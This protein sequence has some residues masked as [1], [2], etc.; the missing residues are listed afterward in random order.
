MRSTGKDLSTMNS[1]ERFEAACDHRNPD[2]VPIDL[3]AHP[4][5]MTALYQYYDLANDTELLDR[6]GCD[7]Y[8]LS[9]RD[10]SQNESCFDIY[11]GPPLAINE[12]Q[13]TCPFGIRFHRDIGPAKFSTDEAFDGPLYQATSEQ[14]ILRHAWPNPKW[15]DFSLLEE[16]CQANAQRVVVGGTW[17]GI[18][19]DCYRMMGFEN[20]L[21]HMAAE[22][23]LIKT[24]INRMTDF[25]LEL[26][27]RCFEQLPGRIDLWY[28][29]NDFGAQE[30]LIFSREMFLE[31]FSDN[32]RQLIDL[33][34]RYQIKV[35]CHS[36]GCIQQLI[37]DLIGLG[38][39]VLDPVQTTAANMK[40]DDLKRDFGN[41][42]VFHGGVDTQ[43]IL[44]RATPQQVEQHC[45]YLI[46]TLGRDGGYIFSSCNSISPDTPIA[47]I[48]AMYRTALTSTANI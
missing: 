9:A 44:T 35:M 40:A 2:R 20:F 25:Y 42:L 1:R 21:Y 13:R 27:E 32:Y 12:T 48:D 8:Y 43:Q 24:L 23:A 45:Q 26:N 36:C 37:G 6:L 38:I 5:I 34:H 11:Q 3:H 47:N 30:G 4:R 39:D 17:A 18:L 14:D 33:A 22:P 7:F 19:G 28:F 31:F 29:G 41:Q 15:F 10:L 16:Q 46:D